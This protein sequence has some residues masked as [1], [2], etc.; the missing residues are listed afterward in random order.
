MPPKYHIQVENSAPSQG[1]PARSVCWATSILKAEGIY[2]VV[3]LGCGRL[4]NLRPLQDHFG[5]ITLVDTPLQCARIATSGANLS[6]ARLMTIDEFKAEDRTYDAIF[7]ISVLHVLDQLSLR[8]ELLALARCKLHNSG[9]LV[10]DVPSG[11]QYYRVHCTLAN[12]YR[13]GWVMGNGSKKTFYRNYYADELDKLVLSSTFF[14]LYKKTWFDKHLI[15][16][17]QKRD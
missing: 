7:L 2:S 6:S 4:R 14:K 9:F 15:R 1:K 5:D 8:K 16:I 13:D 12:K 3:D 10:V 11:I 17:W